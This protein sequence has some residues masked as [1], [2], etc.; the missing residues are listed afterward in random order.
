MEITTDWDNGV[1]KLTIGIENQ[2]VLGLILDGGSSV[3]ILADA[4][5]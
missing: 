3:N 1:P 4:M 2:Q 5:R